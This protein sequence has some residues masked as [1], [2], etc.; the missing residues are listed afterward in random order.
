M[1]EQQL[2]A[3]VLM[4]RPANF[5]ANPQTAGSNHF[6]RPEA[7]SANAL[8][9]A[10]Q[11]FD[12]FADALNAAGIRVHLFDDL[13]APIA[14][15]ALFPNNWVSF[16]ADGTAVLYPMLA[17]NRRLE[18]RRDILDSLVEDHRFN[19]ERLVDLTDLEHSGYFLEG[20]GSMVLDRRNRIAYACLSP[21]THR[22]ALDVFAQRLDYDIVAFDAVDSSGR[23]IYHTNVMLSIGNYFA[24]I[25]AEAIPADQRERVLDRLHT[26]RADIVQLTQAQVADFAGNML[27]LA[28]AEGRSIV[29][30]SKR[31]ANV[32]T[33]EQLN[34]LHCVSGGIVTVPLSTIET[35]GGGSAR[36][37][38]AEL[39]LTHKS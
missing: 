10:R 16:H 28:T 4:I 11:E 3:D 17:P 37:M 33:S 24:A 7:A 27:E 8:C 19:I 31:A 32:L 38:L 39:H 30:M 13:P 23:A 9:D 22:Q 5:C 1:I 29:T 35:L 26:T 25:C 2:T 21:R 36:C 20:T 34:R 12:A 18:R 15:D 14:P 6:Q